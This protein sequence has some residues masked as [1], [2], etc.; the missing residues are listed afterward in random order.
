ML[1]PDYNDIVKQLS[2]S[3]GGLL[4]NLATG[5]GKT[6]LAFE[7]IL[8]TIEYGAKV[9]YITPLR[10]QANELF[11]VWSS[12]L[13]NYAVGIYTGEFA[14]SELPVPFKTA[15]LLIMTPERLD[16]CTRFWRNHWS[17]IPS[18]KLLVIDEIHLLGDIHRG[19]RLE[20]ATTR[21]RRLNPFSRIIGLTATI[22]N[23]KSLASWLQIEVFQSSWRPIPL[24]WKQVSFK[25]AKDKKQTLTDLIT[26]EKSQSIIFVQSRRKAEEISSHLQENGV[27]ASH[28]HAGLDKSSREQV[29]NEFRQRK[30][31]V[32]V[33]T[34]TLEMGVNLPAGHVVIYD[35][36]Q[37]DGFKFSNITTNS[38]WQR[39]GRA[40]RPGL[41]SK[42]LATIFTPEWNKN[43]DNIV[44][45]HFEAIKSPLESD[46][47]LA[48]QLI[49]EVSSG[50][51]KEEP[52]LLRNL[53]LYF[54]TDQQRKEQTKRILR[55]MVAAGMLVEFAPDTAKQG[56]QL[57]A[58]KLGRLAARNM[59]QPSTVLLFKKIIDNY[60][61]A[62]IFDY[63]LSLCSTND[64]E[65]IIPLDYELLAQLQA[66][67]ISRQ[68][69]LLQEDEV[70]L[71]SVLNIQGKR[72]I[73]A[74]AMACMLD[75]FC[76]GIF[77]DDLAIRWGCYP[78]EISRVIES[79]IR[80][81]STF[82][83]CI[84]TE[85]EEATSTDSL[86][87]QL[88][89]NLISTM[90]Q[91]GCNSKTASLTFVEGIGPK[92]A[93]KLYD[94][95][96]KDLEDLSLAEP[97]YLSEIQGISFSRAKRWINIA[98]QLVEDGYLSTLEQW[99]PT[100]NLTK[101][102]N[103]E[104]DVYRLIRSQELS[105]EEFPESRFR[106][107]GG[108]EPHFLRIENKTLKC[109]CKDFSKGHIC[110]HI[111][112]VRRH[113]EDPFIL[114]EIENLNKRSDISSEISLKD[115]WKTDLA[116]GESSWR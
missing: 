9:I 8:R 93:K 31:S 73:N 15:D 35:A 17:W 7:Q 87:I 110:K 60:Q 84:I 38:A 113:K 69:L 39:A 40:G 94:N 3:K 80:L 16:A 82:K 24:E 64:C 79:C 5:S 46:A 32:L 81:T 77:V 45:G 33:C 105:V 68:T 55:E 18:I 97:E 67:L 20:G 41:D 47:N 36:Q 59:V 42:A 102:T 30:L 13:E 19:S 56:L 66:E 22:G 44:N 91:I 11:K 104:I 25:Q 74:L 72:L 71:R 65:P 4:L 100:A 112:A 115:I 21:F 12:R 61:H 95:E 58:T 48:E 109:D 29:E 6:H 53:N 34:P 98:E 116:A 78:F 1:H 70:R 86:T 85:D 54:S 27:L 90:L 37:Y 101:H 75:E 63:F 2:Q 28:H 96:I 83:G 23:P 114:Q 92:L 88:K 26:N 103:F 76:Q 108:S 43:I 99:Q 107:E 49:V 62:S 52:Q 106:V 89:L 111:L 51:A 50:F 10:A 14:D 57:R